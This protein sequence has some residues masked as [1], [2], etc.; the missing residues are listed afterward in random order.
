MWKMTLASSIASAITLLGYWGIPAQLAGST[1]ITP[2]TAQ[3]QC[4]DNPDA[5]FA[6][7]RQ[8]AE[9][10]L[11]S[12]TETRNSLR[13]SSADVENLHAE[14]QEKLS[15]AS[16]AAQD[17]RAAWQ[18]DSFPVMI[19]GR[20]Y[21]KNDVEAQTSSLLAQIDGYNEAI[22]KYTR[23]IADIRQHVE[24]L[25]ARIVTTET[26]LGLLDTRCRMYKATHSESD[27]AALMAAV[28]SLFTE[29]ATVISA[30]PIRSV[31]EMIRDTA[32]ATPVSHSRAVSFLTG[33]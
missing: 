2:E 24:D 1:G 8:Q 30:S 25:T 29:N 12:M 18:A 26:D 10:D 15:Y 14:V 11:R 20:A 6:G 9:A 27:A 5:F 22:A 21:T 28:D 17:F 33:K 7:V 13:T 23:T 3:E 31:D 16:S 19:R 4:R 32:T